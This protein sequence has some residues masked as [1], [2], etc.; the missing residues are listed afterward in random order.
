MSDDK[1]LVKDKASGL[2]LIEAAAHLGGRLLMP[3]AAALHRQELASGAFGGTAALPETVRIVDHGSD[4]TVF[5]FSSAGLLHSGLP[6]FAFTGLF[7]RQSRPY[8][9]VFLRDI[10][11]TAYHLTPDQKPNGLRHYEAIIRQAMEQLGATRHIAIGESSG[12]AAALYFGTRCGM[13][14]VIAFAVPYPL[15]GWTSW[16]TILR[17][18]FNLPE[19][20]RD[21]PSYWDALL[22]MLFSVLA[23]RALT[24]HVGEDGIFDPVE[25]YLGAKTRPQLALYYGERCRPDALIAAQLAQA[26]EA[27]CVSFPTGRHILWV[28]IARQGSLEQLLRDQLQARA[29][30]ENPDSA[31]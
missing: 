29:D 10:H 12:A 13:D 27:Q 6:T 20:L 21:P 5:S 3:S 19:L 31:P 15:K 1:A 7:E 23:K 16:S 22:I 30:L 8:N 18:L 24:K 28:P 2:G 25:T 26:P 17:T 14:K 9:L 4:T 11:R